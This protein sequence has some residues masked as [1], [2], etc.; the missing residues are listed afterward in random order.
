MTDIPVTFA[1]ETGL[2]DRDFPTLL[3]AARYI[4]KLRAML[5]LVDGRRPEIM[6]RDGYLARSELPGG[7]MVSVRVLDGQA[8]GRGSLLGYLLVPG[9]EGLSAWAR[10]MAAIV[11]AQAEIDARNAGI[12]A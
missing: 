4:V 8:S 6:A 7:R 12:A 1:V 10:V 9:P 2:P 5:P 11:Q 3:A